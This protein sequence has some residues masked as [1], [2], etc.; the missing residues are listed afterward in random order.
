MARS[1][2]WAPG[3][4]RRRSLAV[5]TVVAFGGGAKRVVERK[6]DDMV[7]EFS[8]WLWLL[9]LLLLLLKVGEERAP[10]DDPGKFVSVQLACAH[11]PVVKIESRGHS[12]GRSENALQQESQQTLKN[13]CLLA[14]PHRRE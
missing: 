4:I 3:S 11:Q 10:A 2:T 1:M 8:L 7:A 9:L 12:I 6:E 13:P 5:V 14:V